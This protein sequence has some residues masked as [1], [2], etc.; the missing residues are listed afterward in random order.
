MIPQNPRC[1]DDIVD[2]LIWPINVNRAHSARISLS[3]TWVTL[4]RS[5]PNYTC[6]FKL[7]KIPLVN[8]MDLQ[9]IFPH[10]APELIQ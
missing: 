2:V 3:R 10:D 8:S 5:D 1:P 9:L 4:K 6:P 7:T